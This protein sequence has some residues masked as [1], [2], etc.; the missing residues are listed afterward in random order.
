M[1]TLNKSITNTFFN[2]PENGYSNLIR[3]WKQYTN[4]PDCNLQSQHYLLY[5]ILRGK[6]YSKGFSP[7][8]NAIKLENGQSPLQAFNSAKIYCLSDGKYL[9]AAYDHLIFKGLL[10]PGVHLLLKEILG[11]YENPY[12]D[13]VI[14]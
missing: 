12:K 10:V 13:M 7:I 1:Q 6:D 9:T 8:T 4:N 3:T 11:T 14:A 2:D 5:S